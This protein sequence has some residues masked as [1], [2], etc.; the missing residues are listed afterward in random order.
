M[1]AAGYTKQAFIGII[2]FAAANNTGNNTRKLGYNL[3]VYQ[4]KE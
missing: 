4:D 1:W 2:A 3:R